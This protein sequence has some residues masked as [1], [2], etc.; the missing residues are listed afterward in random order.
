MSE[1]EEDSNMITVGAVIRFAFIFSK[2]SV[3]TYSSIKVATRY[4]HTYDTILMFEIWFMILCALKCLFLMPQMLV[5]DN[6]NYLFCA[7]I[8]NSFMWIISNH[9][10]HEKMLIAVYRD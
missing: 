2:G 3:V 8:F 7:F 5:W 9:H 4:Y 1:A 6:I 10:L